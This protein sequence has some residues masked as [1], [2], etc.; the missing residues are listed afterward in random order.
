MSHHRKGASKKKARNAAA[1]IVV[2]DI[3]RKEGGR[4]TYDDIDTLYQDGTCTVTKS[5]ITL[6]SVQETISA[7]HGPFGQ[8]LATPGTAA[9]AANRD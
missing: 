3:L 5:V 2:E 6:H 9:P 8:N 1:K 4:P 7:K